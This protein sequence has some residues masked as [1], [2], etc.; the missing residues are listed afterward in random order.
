MPIAHVAVGLKAMSWP[1]I[2]SGRS[3]DPTVPAARLS[4]LF[5]IAFRG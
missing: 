1:L 5:A 3:F 4:A 2:A